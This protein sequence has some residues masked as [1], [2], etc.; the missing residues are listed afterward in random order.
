MRTLFINLNHFCVLKRILTRL[1]TQEPSAMA[2]SVILNKYIYFDQVNCQRT[3]VMIFCC[4]MMENTT[5]NLFRIKHEQKN[6]KQQ[7]V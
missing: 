3:Q 5:I 6:S 4:T 1:N 2:V 7:I